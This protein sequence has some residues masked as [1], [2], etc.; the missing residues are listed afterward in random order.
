MAFGLHFSKLRAQVRPVS[1]TKDIDSVE[2][3]FTLTITGGNDEWVSQSIGNNPDYK[4]KLNADQSS[5]SLRILVKSRYGGGSKPIPNHKMVLKKGGKEIQSTP[6]ATLS[7]SENFTP[8]AAQ[9]Y[10]CILQG[11]GPQVQ[12]FTFSIAV[13]QEN[14]KRQNPILLLIQLP[15]RATHLNLH[16]TSRPILRLLPKLP[17][18]RIPQLRKR[19]MKQQRHNQGL[20]MQEIPGTNLATDDSESEGNGTEKEGIDSNETDANEGDDDNSKVVNEEELSLWEKI[21]AFKEQNP[22][23]FWGGVGVSG[24]LLLLVLS[25]AL[26]PKKKDKPKE[27]KGDSV[28]P[29]GQQ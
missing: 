23:V 16:L 2:C 12:L 20:R 28:P 22:P 8:G 15:L 25:R 14:R 19:K 17:A 4:F 1:T 10:N 18:L 9:R 6:G 7:T 26:K 27:S 11:P 29:K 21:L 13:E 24:L 5:L 3:K